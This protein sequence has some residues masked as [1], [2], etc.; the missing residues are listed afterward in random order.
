MRK[1]EVKLNRGWLSLTTRSI[2]LRY[3]SLICLKPVS[4]STDKI[5]SVDT[6]FEHIAKYY[7]IKW[8]KTVMMTG[9]QYSR[10]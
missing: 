6:G 5:A 9:L 7:L 2:T 3:I 4:C 1:L 10:M 8:L